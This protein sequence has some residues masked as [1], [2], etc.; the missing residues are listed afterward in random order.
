MKCGDCDKQHAPVTTFWQWSATQKNRTP[1]QQVKTTASFQ[2]EVEQLSTDTAGDQTS[3]LARTSVWRQTRAVRSWESQRTSSHSS[4]QGVTDKSTTTN[5]SATSLCQKF[6]STDN[7]SYAGNE[8]VNPEYAFTNI[9]NI[10]AGRR[11]KLC[12]SCAERMERR[13]V[14]HVEII[15]QHFFFY[16]HMDVAE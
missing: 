4:D 2:E 3:K 12:A 14:E 13:R 16:G 6:L 7:T 9:G 11:G 10:E 15:T 1:E 5:R 8:W